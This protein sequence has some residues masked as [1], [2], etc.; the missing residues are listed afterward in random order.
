MFTRLMTSLRLCATLVAATLIAGCAALAPP[1]RAPVTPV[2]FDLIG[3]VAVSYD[4]RAFSSNVRWHHL[5]ARDELW[6]MTPA[7]QTLAHIV[8][9]GEG[10]T[11]TGADRSQY[12]AA[13]VESLT[14]QGLGWELPLT[15]LGWWVRGEAAPGTTA[16][17]IER[18]ERARL[19]GL[20]QDGWHIT[21]VPDPLIENDRLPRRLEL[22]DGRHVIRLVIDGWR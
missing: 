18:D 13:D 12:S 20:T 14:R 4:G 2:P 1:A 22:A 5:S 15:H 11:L 8:S 16:Q 7:G 17:N 19:V 9:D 10:A 3:R 6:L 21:L